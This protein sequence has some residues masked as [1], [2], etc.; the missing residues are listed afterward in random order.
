MNIVEARLNS[1]TVDE[2]V[3]LH[4]QV[5]VQA[6]RLVSAEEDRTKTH[7]NLLRV[8]A[9]LRSILS[10]EDS[11]MNR[12]YSANLNRG[13]FKRAM[14]MGKLALKINVA[15]SRKAVLGEVTMSE[16]IDKLVAG[17]KR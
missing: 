9:G 17:A 12:V 2:L 1:K 10:V 5:R 11:E 14:T 8:V 15:V 13:V 6:E 4:R 3:G 7:L 16:A